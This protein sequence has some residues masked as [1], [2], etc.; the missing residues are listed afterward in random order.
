M[1]K[2]GQELSTNTIIVVILAVLV[3]I[4]VAI[5]FTGGFESFKNKVGNL[6]KHSALDVNE[7][8][9]ECNSYCSKYDSTGLD[10]YKNNYCTHD[11]DLDTTGDGKVDEVI[12]CQDIPQISCQAIESTGG[13]FS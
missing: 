6:W 4:V 3:L 5:F 1:K 13:C 2:R 11:F 12:R 8:I 10:N 7:I 9:I